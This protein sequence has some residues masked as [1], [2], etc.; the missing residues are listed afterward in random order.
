MYGKEIYRGL[1]LID[2]KQTHLI[3]YAEESLN[4]QVGREICEIYGNPYKK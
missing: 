3:L 2:R 1:Y 4:D